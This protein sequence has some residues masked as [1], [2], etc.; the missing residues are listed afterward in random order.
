MIRKIKM[1]VSYDGTDFLGWQIQKDDRTVAGVLESTYRRVFGEKISILG[2]SRTDSGVHAL[3]QVAIFR[4]ELEILN[5]K[6]LFAWNAS[7]PS[8]IVIRSLKDCT[9]D[10]HPFH[11]VLSKTYYYHVFLNRPLPFFARFGW[12]YP[13]S[14]SLRMDVLSEALQLFVG[15][16]DFGSF[17]TI[18][19][20]EPQ[21]TI[22]TVQSIRLKKISR[23]GLLQIAVV[24]KSFARFQIRRMVGAAL[25]VARR[26]ELQA[27]EITKMLKNPNSNQSL[28]KAPAEGLCLRRIIYE[29]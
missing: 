8:S 6:M 17:C 7:L 10:F 15:T 27:H 1:I 20:D 3:G 25:D 21:D 13:Y 2:A 12:R 9:D 22:R 14:E 28:V 16:H 4:T 26:P 19:Q 29:D 11:R 23:F 24:G 18:D 5:E